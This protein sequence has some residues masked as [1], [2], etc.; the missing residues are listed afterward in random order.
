MNKYWFKSRI[1]TRVSIGIVDRGVNARWY[2]CQ[3][4]VTNPSKANAQS[5]FS[6]S[7]SISSSCSTNFSRYEATCSLFTNKGLS[8]VSLPDL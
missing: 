3:R 8:C 7:K 6:E 1:K 2:S 4:W 5:F